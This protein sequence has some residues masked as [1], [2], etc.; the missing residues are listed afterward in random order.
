MNDVIS[1]MGENYYG[2]SIPLELEKS[3]KFMDSMY[4]LFNKYYKYYSDLTKDQKTRAT[5]LI[6]KNNNESEVN[7]E[8]QYLYDD[9]IYVDIKDCTT[10]P[11]PI[12][13]DGDVLGLLIDNYPQ[14]MKNI[15]NE[16]NIKF[17][18]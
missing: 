18:E 1:F 15:F 4:R 17:E 7:N 13:T 11:F 16:L 6:I 12:E 3:K 14:E 2:E 10:L 9:E 5:N 8:L